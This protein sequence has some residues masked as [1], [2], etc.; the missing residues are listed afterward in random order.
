M[1]SCF[2]NNKLPTVIAINFLHLIFCFRIVFSSAV[3][4]ACLQ[5]DDKRDMHAYFTGWGAQ[6]AGSE[7]SDTLHSVSIS[8]RNINIDFNFN[9]SVSEL[10]KS[11]YFS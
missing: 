11:C 4:P 6:S 2:G 1:V 3:L 9:Q 7:V 8:A 5:V 10:H